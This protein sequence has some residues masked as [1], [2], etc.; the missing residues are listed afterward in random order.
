[1]ENIRKEAVTEVQTILRNWEQGWDSWDAALATQDY[2][3]DADWINAFGVDR[4]GREEIHEF[5]AMVF[6]RPQ[7]RGRVHKY[8]F[9]QIRMISEDVA[10]AISKGETDGQLTLDGIPMDT[11]KTSH[12]RL[13]KKTKEGW[14]IFS[15]LISDTRERD[16]V[17]H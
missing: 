3:C 16:A 6:E 2:T 7:M 4:K 1:M 10:Y 15:H 14:K 11:R 12:L 17:K 8:T 5:L 13:I 9:E